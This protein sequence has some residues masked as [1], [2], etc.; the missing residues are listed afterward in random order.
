M[1]E[2]FRVVGLA[3]ALAFATGTRSWCD[4]PE[5]G[6]NAFFER[7]CLRYDRPSFSNALKDFRKSAE[8]EAPLSDYSVYSGIMIWLTRAR[9]GEQQAAAP[10]LEACLASRKSVPPDDWPSQVM[11]CLLGK[12]PGPQLQAYFYAGTMRLLA[13]DKAAARDYFEKCVQTGQKQCTEYTGAA[14]ELKLMK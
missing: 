11:R 7:G 10:E 9:M 5:G 6:R 13:G 8:L 1:R 12:L 4:A 3:I 14:A 2:S